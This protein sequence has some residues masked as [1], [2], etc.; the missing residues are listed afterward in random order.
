MYDGYIL[1][2]GSLKQNLAG[3][4]LT[5]QAVALLE[6]RNV[7][8]HPQYVVKRKEPVELDKPPSFTPNTIADIHP[9]FHRYAVHKMIHDFKQTVCNTLEVPL[10]LNAI[11]G[12]PAKPYEFP[13]GFNTFF[14]AERYYIPELM[15]NPRLSGSAEFARMSFCR[16]QLYT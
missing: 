2:K 4:F 13:S 15:F 12:R 8:M 9:S 6:K 16:S 7:A 14:R 1:Q 11:N 3:G 5:E 10:D